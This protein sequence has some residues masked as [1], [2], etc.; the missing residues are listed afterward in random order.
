MRAAP[1]PCVDAHLFV[2]NRRTTHRWHGD[3]PVRTALLARSALIVGAVLVAVGTV[4]SL[5]SGPGGPSGA[6]TAPETSSPTQSEADPD[7]ETAVAAPSASVPPVQ[8]ASASGAPS[9][10]Q[11]PAAPVSVQ[12][13]RLGAELPI[14]PTGVATD[15]QME[16]PVDA[17]EAGW[18]RYGTAPGAGTGSAV[19]AAHAGSEETPEGPLYAIREAEPGDEVT[20]TDEEGAVHAYEVTSVEQLGKEGLDFTPYFARSGPERLVLIT[21]GGQWLPENRSYADN[22][23]VVAVPVR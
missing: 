19:I 8:I 17:A 20:V 2:P 15:G 18:Y 13:P 9:A 11:R 22:I 4:N 10:G 7:A 14:T 16:I 23:I 5:D 1:P 21:C 6:G 12:Y 3:R